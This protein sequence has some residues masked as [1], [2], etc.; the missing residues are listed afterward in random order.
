MLEIVGLEK[1][2]GGRTVLAGLSLS[3]GRGASVALLGGNG[4][5]KTTTLRCVAGLA[6]P[7][8]GR[9]SVCGI[10]A[11]AEGKRARGRLS[12][13]PQKSAF[14]ATLSVRETLEIV[15]RLRGQSDEDVAAELAECELADLAGRSVCAL[16]GGER[17]RLGLAAAFLP[18]VDLYLFDEPTASL[19]PRALEIFRR[20]AR[21]LTADG[22]AV[23][24]TT[25]VEA[26][27]EALATRV[28]VLEGGR[29]ESA[30]GTPFFRRPAAR[31]GGAVLAGPW[32]AGR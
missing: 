23:L 14:P 31:S 12:F 32:S 6:L 26:D 8:A 4:C 1:R 30:A 15:A 17:Q 2:F 10:D 20:R 29:L 18:R 24:F 7:D 11:L 21:R 28:E 27:V 25:H 3:V 5:G 13:L 9:I 22:R 19:D 16:S